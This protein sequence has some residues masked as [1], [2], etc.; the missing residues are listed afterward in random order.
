MNKTEQ[1]K[2]D[3]ECYGGILLYMTETNCQ[4]LTLYIFD[5]VVSTRFDLTVAL[6]I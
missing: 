4:S 1:S 3:E 2:V 6:V 5:T